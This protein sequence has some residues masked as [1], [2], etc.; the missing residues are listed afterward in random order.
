[1]TT[2]I[3]GLV[4]FSTLIVLLSLLVLRLRSWLIPSTPVAIAVNQ[5]P[6]KTVN[7][8]GKL[9]QVLTDLDVPVPSACA[10]AGTCGLCKVAVLDGG[11]PLLSTE[12]S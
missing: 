4:F 9:L 1:M 6:P 7:S 8:G 2:T 10:G 11:G 5:Q 12:A 3:L